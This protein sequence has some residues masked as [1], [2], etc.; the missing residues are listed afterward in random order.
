METIRKIDNVDVQKS[1]NPVVN[2]NSNLKVLT[3]FSVNAFRGNFNS[4]ESV[5]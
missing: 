2:F 1:T 3:E 5:Y 4:T